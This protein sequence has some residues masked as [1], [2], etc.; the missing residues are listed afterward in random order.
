[1]SRENEK[2]KSGNA[3]INALKKSNM[4][5]MAAILVVMIIIASIVSPYFLN[6]YNLQSVLRDLAFVGMIGIAQSL[7]LLVG[8]LDLSVGKIACLSG[9]LT[10]MLMVNVGLNPWLCLVIGLILGLL[11]GFINGII[12]TRLRLNSMVAGTWKTVYRTY[13]NSVY[14]LSCCFDPDS[15]YGKEDKDGSLHICDW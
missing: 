12:I 2:Q 13:T 5:A 11:F 9:I 8:E 7:L 6:V 10:G 15:I 14:Y 3:F 1:M 4:T